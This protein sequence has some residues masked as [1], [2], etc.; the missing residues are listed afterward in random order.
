MTA[1]LT[2]DTLTRQMS[3][4]HARLKNPR[5]AMEAVGVAIVSITKRAHTDA[6]LRPHVWPPL[7][8]GKASTLQKTTTLRRGWRVTAVE[9]DSVTV[10]NAAKYAAVHFSGGQTGPHIIRP[11]K[12]KGLKFM[13]GNRVIIRKSVKHPG[14]KIPKR[15]AMPVHDDGTLTPYAERVVLHIF[16][17]KV[18]QG[19]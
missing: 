12:K 5:S 16:E 9:G 8:G 18:L 14:S 7:H 1:T 3:A 4:L 17:Q 6:S 11:K 2:Q 15:R 13:I 19:K 10:G